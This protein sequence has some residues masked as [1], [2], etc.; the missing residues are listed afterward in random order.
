MQRHINE[1]D[2][3]WYL[4]ERADYGGEDYTLLDAENRD[5]DGDGE[6]EIVAGGGEVKTHRDP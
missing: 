1:A 2:Q 5:G 3:D 6:F 4:N